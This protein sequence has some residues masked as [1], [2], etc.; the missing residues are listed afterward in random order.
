MQILETSDIVYLAI[1]NYP[2]GMY[3]TQP[4][5]LSRVK[6]LPSHQAYCAV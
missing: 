4:E 5:R 2:L 1:N 3:Q 6:L